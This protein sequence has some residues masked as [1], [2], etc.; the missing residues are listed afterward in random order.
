M[1]LLL[2]PAHTVLTH[3]TVKVSTGVRLSICRPILPESLPKL[4]CRSTFDFS[5]IDSVS[6][7]TVNYLLQGKSWYTKWLTVLEHEQVITRW[8][9]S[10]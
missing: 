3:P 1:W 2:F 9:Q 4:T 8:G 6:E 5:R 7:F 10:L